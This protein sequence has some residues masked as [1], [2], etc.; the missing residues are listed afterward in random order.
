MSDNKNTRII[1]SVLLI[2]SFTIGDY[3]ATTAVG[4]ALRQLFPHAHITLMI[5][6]FGKEFFEHATWFDEIILFELPWASLGL[7]QLAPNLWFNMVRFA[8][9]LRRKDFDFVIV[10]VRNFRHWLILNIIGQHLKLIPPRNAPVNHMEHAMSVVRV[11]GYTGNGFPKIEI[12]EENI[13]KAKQILRQNGIKAHNFIVLHPGASHFL[14]RW[15]S[16]RFVQLYNLLKQDGWQVIYM[17]H[18]REDDIFIETVKIE[19]K[20]AVIYFDLP[21][22]LSIA[23]ISLASA[24][25]AMDSGFSHIS[26]ALGIPTVALYGPSSA[27]LSGIV[28]R[29][30]H[31]V[32][33][34]ELCSCRPK[35]RYQNT[36]CALLNRPCEAMASISAEQ[37][38]TALSILLT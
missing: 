32:V 27:K 21:L 19:M 24:T 31:R 28:G 1:T 6:P 13:S 38:Y 20:Q 2:E 30:V 23:V 25:V 4:Q 18:G 29:K 12:V 8:W 26:A 36:K 11:L 5:K 15:T 14:K 10:T 7:R 34:N 37:V 9:V 17:G 22:P 33:H 35:R 16:D 3:C